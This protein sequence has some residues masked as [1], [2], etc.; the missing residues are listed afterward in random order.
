[1]VVG[2]VWLVGGGDPLG[3]FGGQLVPVAY[4]GIGGL[5]VQLANEQILILETLGNSTE[6]IIEFLGTQ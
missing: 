1:V 4:A 3:G 2:V 6:I 5:P